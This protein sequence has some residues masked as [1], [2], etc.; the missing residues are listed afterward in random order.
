MI[1][2]VEKILRQGGAD[3]LNELGLGL[4]WRNGLGVVRGLTPGVLTF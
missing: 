2:P 3:G 1:D 4:R